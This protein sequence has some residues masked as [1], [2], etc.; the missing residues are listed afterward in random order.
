VLG[1]AMDEEQGAGRGLRLPG[2]PEQPQPVMGA[3]MRL[4]PAQRPSAVLDQDGISR[5]SRSRA[6]RMRFR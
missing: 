5:F 2:A 3:E 4:D 1:V 6:A